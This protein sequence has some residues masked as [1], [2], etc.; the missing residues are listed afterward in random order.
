MAEGNEKSG[1]LV[2]VAGVLAFI[3]AAIG[4]AVIA[5]NSV[6][7]KYGYISFLISSSLFVW[8]SIKTKANLS[9]LATNAMYLLINLYGLY[10]WIL[11]A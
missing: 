9:F 8:L 10:K 11:T 7:S 3:T 4:A 1:L 2:R 6:Y 5:D